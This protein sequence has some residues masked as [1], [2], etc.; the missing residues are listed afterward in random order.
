MMRPLAMMMVGR[1][2]MAARS[3][4]LFI[5]MNDT[6]YERDQKRE[7]SHQAVDQRSAG[8]GHRDGRHVG[9]QNDGDQLVR[10]QR[11]HLPLAE[12]AEEEKHGGVEDDDAQEDDE[13]VG[14][15]P[16]TVWGAAR[17]IY[18]QAGPCTGRYG[19][20]HRCR[21]SARPGSSDGQ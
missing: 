11:G 20:T 17:E 3:R 4:V 13:Q 2:L 18:A 8:G 19:S 21:E 9:Q 10:L 5:V 14:R 1:P 16:P 12:D 6:V 7:Q 15:P